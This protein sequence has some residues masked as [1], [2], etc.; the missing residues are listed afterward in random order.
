MG[1]ISVASVL[2]FLCGAIYKIYTIKKLP[3]CLPSQTYPIPASPV[4][5]IIKEVLLFGEVKKRNVKMWVLTLFL[6]WGI[7]S[8]LFYVLFIALISLT[9]KGY[10]LDTKISLFPCFMGTVGSVGIIILR[11]SKRS[12]RN[13]TGL[14]RWFNL[15]ILAF[16]FI[17]GFF[18]AL[19]DLFANA[20]I[21]LLYSILYFD[22]FEFAIPCKLH[23]L[24]VFCFVSM[25]PFTSMFHFVMKYFTFHWIRWG[26]RVSSQ[27]EI[28]RYFCYELD[29]QL[30]NH[31][32]RHHAWRDLLIGNNHG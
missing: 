9:L 8:Y 21:K 6:H 14:R 17:T 19:K 15:S 4:P 18:C 2:V 22:L 20:Y 11:L 30:P 1:I 32:L 5:Y 7:Y 16:M 24:T 31:N 25:L 26:Q 3:L 28:Q 23:L 13:L 27:R 10:K 12:L 29:W